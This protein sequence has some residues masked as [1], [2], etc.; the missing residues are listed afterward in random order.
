MYSIQF[1]VGNKMLIT[2]LQMKGQAGKKSVWI[3]AA[4]SHLIHFLFI[5]FKPCGFINLGETRKMGIQ[6]QNIKSNYLLSA[7][8]VLLA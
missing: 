2:Q 7:P 6:Q 3:V 4:D 5:N 8:K 1:K